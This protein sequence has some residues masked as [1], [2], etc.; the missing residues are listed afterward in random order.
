MNM[1][2]ETNANETE[3]D[4]NTSNLA[5]DDKDQG[6]TTDI[7]S[8]QLKQLFIEKKPENRADAFK[9]YSD[10]VI[11]IQSQTIPEIFNTALGN[12][13]RDHLGGEKLPRSKNAEERE[14]LQKMK[15]ENLVRAFTLSANQVK[16]TL[17]KV[18]P[19]SPD[20][21]DSLA[22]A[23][24]QLFK[25]KRWDG[26]LEK[27]DFAVLLQKYKDKMPKSESAQKNKELIEQGTDVLINNED[28]IESWKDA[29]DILTNPDSI[30]E[31][32]AEWVRNSTHS[33]N[34]MVNAFISQTD[35]ELEVSET[36][37][38]KQEIAIQA[39]KMTEEEI[40]AHVKKCE[41]E[42]AIDQLMWKLVELNKLGWYPH[43]RLGKLKI[44]QEHYRES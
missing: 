24:W 5:N 18:T 23:T 34:Q 13:E 14:K 22:W 7:N 25:D 44:I 2:E 9:I 21:E 42:G 28:K 26:E 39:H 36:S 3:T 17:A 8:E 4:A 10:A 33:F 15:R 40:N 27:E 37:K 43:L 41:E 16:E 31:E 6:N 29:Y 30:N 1:S 32:L 38:A 20:E 11:E 19:E 35:K 12:Y